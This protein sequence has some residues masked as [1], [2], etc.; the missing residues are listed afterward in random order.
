MDEQV[1]EHGRLVVARGRKYVVVCAQLASGRYP[2][3]DFLAACCKKWP[4]EASRLSAKFKRF[5]RHGQVLDEHSFHKL[6]DDIWQFR[7]GIFRVLCY[8]EEGKV[9]LTHGF[10]KQSK[11]TPR[12]ELS[13]AA[14]IRGEDRARA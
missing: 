4:N 2:A 9:I 7:S 11:K 8:I 13:R 12:R 10:K 6:D 1:D 3:A 14:A 5:S